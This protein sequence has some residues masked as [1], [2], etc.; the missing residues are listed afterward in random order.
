MLDTDTKR[1]INTCRDILVGKVPDPK[2]QVEQ[3][4]IA[5]I[6]KFMDDMDLE[7]EEVGFDRKFFTGEYERYR[8]AKLLAPGVGGQEML[9]TYTEALTKM[10]EN[11]GIPELFRSIFRNAYLPYRDPETLRGFL[12]E[13]NGFTY[14][15]SER[16]G[17]AF[18]YLLS[19]L[20]SQGDAG[21]FRT[22]RHIIDFMV[23]IIDPKK[24]EV[25]L[26]PAC[27]TAGFLISSYK[28]ILKSNSTEANG[29]NG[30]G[31]EVDASEA[32]IDSPLR[33]A[34]DMLTQDD[35]A[36]LAGNIRGYDIS[37]DMVRLSLVNLYLHGFADPNVEEYDTLTS[38]DRWAETADVILANPPFMSPKGGIK[39]HNRFG[40]QSKR[41]EVLF[42]DYIAEHLNPNGRA[43]IVV[44]EG[45][46]FQSQSAYCDLRRMLV[47]DNYLAAVISLPAGVFNPYS[48]VK[49]SILILDRSV[50]KASENIAFFKIENDGFGL[51]AQ[52]RTMKGSQLPQVKAELG[53]WLK[54]TRGGGEAVLNSSLGLAVEK[55]RIGEDGQYNLSGER[56]RE[57]A[58]AE[59]VVPRV[60][61]GDICVINPRKSKI[62][63]LN[64]ETM[65][66][67]VPMAVLNEHRINFVSDESKL[68]GEVS[69]GYTYFADG[70][71]LL[72]KVTPCFENGK[73]GIARG[74][75]NGIGFGSSEFYVLRPGEQVLAQWVYHCVT[76]P[77]F[78]T[79]AVANMTGTGGL[80]RVPRDFVER[81]EI[82]LPPLEIQR[83]IVAEIEG[84]QKVVD[85]ARAV[86]ENYR[87]H[88]F[89]DATWPVSAIKEIVTAVTPPAKLQTGAYQE[90]GTFPIIDQSQEF[91][92]GWTDSADAVID[93]ADGLVVFGD[94][95]CVIKFVDQPF[96]QGAD[97]IKILK[98]TGN[99]SAAY[100]AYYL[101]AYPLPT[102]GYRRHFSLLK[103]YRVALPPPET[104]QAIVAEIEAEQ[105]LVNANRELIERFNKKIEAAIARVWSDAGEAAAA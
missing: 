2:S 29:G 69:A 56:Y 86:L 79:P 44:P 96:V 15:H 77:S 70:D 83:E 24:D 14:D 66:S 25:I 102:D 28:H 58:P 32:T 67:F 20:G 3:I 101:Q 99:L 93:P 13:I 23:E 21:Q 57:T 60:P 45:I 16:L 12:R 91:I 78:R 54:V 48:G 47:E 64:P 73:A 46:I 81:F 6:Y 4:T 17:D 49:T 26:D 7:A 88:I 1:R 40:V 82:P 74:L 34:G 76:H 39:P 43:A 100:L 18:E 59:F 85:G 10:V 55:A 92:A 65:V 84:Y 105:A 30:H 87:P 104:Q 68:L 98:P 11:P 19:V 22:P 36:R 31:A 5:L 33:Y 38:D 62:G 71:V 61:I 72:A 42:V 53:A 8:W 95:T 9:N 52:R 27:G 89:I 51:G 80:Q 90:A 50:A 75:T 35:R 94:H 103:D 37:P 63:D 41:S 97:G